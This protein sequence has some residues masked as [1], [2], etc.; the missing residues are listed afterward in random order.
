VLVKAK[1]PIKKTRA[2]GEIRSPYFSEGCEKIAALFV[3]KRTFIKK[4]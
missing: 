1:N 3:L 2:A 4:R